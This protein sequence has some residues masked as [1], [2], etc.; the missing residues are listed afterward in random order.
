[1]NILVDLFI[2]PTNLRIKLILFSSFQK[3]FKK[4]NNKNVYRNNRV[5]IFKNASDKNINKNNRVSNLIG[6]SE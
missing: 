3:Y 4:A 2:R 1:M 5:S 6:T